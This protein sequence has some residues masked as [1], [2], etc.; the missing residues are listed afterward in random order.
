MWNLVW[1]ELT[2]LIYLTKIIYVTIDHIFVVDR[3][4][5]N[6]WH[7]MCF[8]LLF[9]SQFN[10]CQSVYVLCF[11]KFDVVDPTILLTICYFVDVY[12][13]FLWLCWKL[14]FSFS[15]SY[16]AVYLRSLCTYPSS[17]CFYFSTYI[18]IHIHPPI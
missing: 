18:C 8:H 7:P 17:I 15:A 2:T 14:F 10:L 9:M 11:W 16:S 12:F 4:C 5:I 13:L 1:I 3:C 6:S